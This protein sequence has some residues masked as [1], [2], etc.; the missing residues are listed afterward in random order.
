MI[1]IEKYKKELKSALIVYLKAC[2][3]FLL[4][5]FTGAI[6]IALPALTFPEIQLSQNFHLGSALLGGLFSQIALL[7]TLR[8]IGCRVTRISNDDPKK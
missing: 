1:Q 7:A 4:N 6:M 3:Y 5:A 2:L 8:F